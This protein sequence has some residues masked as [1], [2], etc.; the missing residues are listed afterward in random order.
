MNRRYYSLRTGKH[1]DGEHLTFKNLLKLFLVVYHD[2]AGKGYFQEAFGYDC[3]DAGWV[4]G[5]LGGDINAHFIRRLR[6]DNLWPIEEKNE[7]YDENDLFDVIEFLYDHVSKPISGK[8]HSWNDCGYHYDTFEKQPGQEEFRK[9]INDLFKDYGSFE[10]SNIGEIFNSPLTGTEDLFNNLP[11][12]FDPNNVGRRIEE[13]TRQYLRHGSSQDDKKQ[14]IQKLVEVFEFL[15]PQI[16]RVLTKADENDLF[17]IANNFGIRHHNKKQK[18]GYDES[19]WLDWMFYYYL[20]TLSTVIKLID[21]EPTST[22][23]AE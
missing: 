9:E 3:V 11:T 5:K 13:A 21:K 22:T 20:A 7:Y 15:R 8:Y 4:P 16:K 14:A 10:L 19:I 12:D 18:T 2:F 23:A 1:P 6:K 17:N